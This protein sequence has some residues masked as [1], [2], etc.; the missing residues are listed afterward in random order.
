MFNN[1]KNAAK[2]TAL[3]IFTFASFTKI[4]KSKVLVARSLNYHMHL[5]S[6][7]ILF[8]TLPDL[9]VKARTSKF[10]LCQNE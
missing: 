5:A 2:E 3:L 1:H 8:T 6:S 10:F 7:N 4:V 9:T